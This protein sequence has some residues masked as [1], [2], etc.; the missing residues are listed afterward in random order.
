MEEANQKKIGQGC[1]VLIVIFAIVYLISSVS[2]KSFEQIE[3]YKGQYKQRVFVYVAPNATIDQMKEHARKQMY[4]DGK[5]TAVFYYT[6]HPSTLN[7]GSVTMARDWSEA[8]D[9]AIQPGCVLYYQKSPEGSEYFSETPWD[10]HVKAMEE[11]AA[12]E[13]WSKEQQRKHQ[14]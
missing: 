8:Y 6:D 12:G 7:Q 3:Y 13:K 4:T 1:L 10:D 2:G 14:K 5:I 9:R 11:D